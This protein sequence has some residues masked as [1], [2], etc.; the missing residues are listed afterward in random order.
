ML[1]CTLLL[2]V[3]LKKYYTLDGAK[4]S[5]K[6]PWKMYQCLKEVIPSMK[7]SIKP[8]ANWRKSVFFNFAENYYSPPPKYI[9]FE[10][11]KQH[12]HFI[13][14]F[15]PHYCD[16]LHYML[17]GEQKL[18]QPDLWRDDPRFG[19]RVL[20]ILVLTSLY[21]FFFCVK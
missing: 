17:L 9:D 14:N 7:C 20:P 2:L 3:R 4:N 6:V 10:W 8:T 15:S 21:L 1:L 16:E 11:G 13:L 19:S 12:I 5:K 18:K